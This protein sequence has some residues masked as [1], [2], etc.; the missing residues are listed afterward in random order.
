MAPALSVTTLPSPGGAGVRLGEGPG[1][2]AEGHGF[3]PFAFLAFLQSLLS[4]PSLMSSP[5]RPAAN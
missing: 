4:L 5:A 2:R 3:R 1:V